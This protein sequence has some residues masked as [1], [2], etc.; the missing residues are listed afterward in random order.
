MRLIRYITA[1]T[2]SAI[3][4]VSCKKIESLPA[5]PHI[6]FR[7]FAVFDTTDILANTCKG[8]RLNFYFED[9]DGDLGLDP[10]VFE[11]DDTVNL[12]FTLYRKTGSIF[13]E[14]PENDLLNPSD[15]RIPYMERT[16][17]NKILKGI[18]SVT[19][20]YLFYDPDDTDTLR[21]EFYI[22]DRGQHISD[23]ASTSEIP[24]SD[25]GLY[26]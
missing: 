1:I 26:L 9:G 12:F 15:Y 10:P 17:Q 11:N 22:K 3:A 8:G 18:I 25:N 16:G 20:L 24:L 2:L 14:V 7:S 5:R 13:T 23:T 19:F 4:V 21:Y 6:E